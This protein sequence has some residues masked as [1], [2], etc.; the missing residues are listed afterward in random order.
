ME[1]EQSC[2]TISRMA[3]PHMAIV[4]PLRAVECS[5]NGQC[6]V[7]DVLPGSVVEEEAW[8]QDGFLKSRVVEEIGILTVN[9]GVRGKRQS[10]GG[11]FRGG[12]VEGERRWL[13]GCEESISWL[14]AWWVGL[15][16]EVAGG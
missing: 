3:W 4:A 1:V 11:K 15:E 9:G 13:G 12:L 5:G 16:G 6:A 14:E 10:E 2:R 8:N 7:E